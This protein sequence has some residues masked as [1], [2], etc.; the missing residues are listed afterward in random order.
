[1]LVV[2]RGRPPHAG[3]WS[4]PGGRVEPG[5]DDAAAVVREL[6]EE[7]GLAV[8]VG[9]LLGVVELGAGIVVH[10][11]RC[12]VVGGT[13]AAGDDA[14]DAAWVTAAELLALPTTPLLWPLL[15][16]WGALPA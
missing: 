15:A 8:R 3:L 16:E 11:Y 9:E 10:D 7:T 4:I 6:A 14:A 2:R 13:L 12:K 1:L 5:E